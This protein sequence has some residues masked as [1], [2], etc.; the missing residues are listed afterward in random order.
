MPVPPKALPTDG[1][2]VSDLK[3][4]P[5]SEEAVDGKLRRSHRLRIT[6]KH[7]V[8][9]NTANEIFYL[10][11][12][13]RSTEFTGER[14][15]TAIEGE[16]EFEHFH[17]Y[18]L[19]RDLCSALDVL[20][21]ASGE[22]YGSSIL[23]N[24]ARSVIGVDVDPVA[25]AHARTAYGEVNLRFVQGSALD[26]P[27]G[28]ASVDVVVSFDTL[29]YVREHARFMAEVKRVLRPNGKL[30]VSS[31]E[32]AVYS[33][34]GEPANKYHLHELTEAEFESL[35][36][37]NFKHVGILSQQAIFGS[38][39]VKTEGGGPWRSY[40]RR[41]LEYIEA[42][43][44][45]TRAPF[46]IAVASDEE[47]LH[48]PSSVYL[49][50]RRPGDVVGGHLQLPRYRPQ[51][52]EMT[53]EIGCLNEAAA[54]RDA[55]IGR[56]ND[57]AA[58]RQAEIERLNEA[59]SA[60]DRELS[61]VKAECDAQIVWLS[62][63]RMRLNGQLSVDAAKLEVL[64][65]Q[66]DTVTQSFAWRF[67]DEAVHFPRT[68]GRVL[69]G[70]FVRVAYH[71]NGRPRSWLRRLRYMSGAPQAAG[72]SGQM[73]IGQQDGWPN[74]SAET[75]S[76]TPSAGSPRAERPSLAIDV[77]KAT[78]LI[79][80]HEATRSG[81]PILALNLVQQL[82]IRYNVISLTLGGGELTDYFRHVSAALYVADRRTMTDKQLNDIVNG[83]TARHSVK[84]AIINSVASSRV[85]S[86]LRAE[87]VPTISLIHEFSSYMRPRSALHDMIDL[88]TETVFS[89][90]LTL[91]SAVSDFWLYQGNSIHVAP[92]GKCIVPAPGVSNAEVEKTWLAANLRPPGASKFLVLG[93]G[94]IELRK[95]VD[96]FIKCAS[97]L[98][99]K[100]GGERFHFV[101][102]GDGFDPENEM[103]YSV[104]LDDQI[105]RAGLELKLKMLRSTSQIELAY[106]S[107]DLLLITSRLDPLPNVAIDALL[108]GRP[109]L[110][111]EKTTGIADFMIENGLGDQCVAKYL[112]THD[113]AE[114]VKA[115]ADSEELRACV[116]DRSRAAA[117]K[118]FDM[119]VYV[120]R[121]E[122]IAMRAVAHD[123][124]SKDESKA[125]LTSGKFRSDFFKHA[126][127][128]EF[129]EEKIIEDYLH[130]MD[131]GLGVRKPMPGFQPSVYSTL[132]TSSGEVKGDPFAD[133]LRNGLPEGPWLQR[134]IQD[135]GKQN[136]SA[137][138]KA[139]VAMHVHAFYSD[140]LRGIV[141]RLNRNASAPDL[142][143][144]VCTS[145]GAAQ[146][147]EAV[148]TY[149][150]RVVDLQITPN[151]GRDIGPF[152]TQFG[153]ELCADY[154]ITGHLHTKKSLHVTDRPFAEAWNT[155]L[156]ENLVGGERGGA[157]LDAILSAMELD[158]AIGIV[159]PDDPHVISWTK[160]RTCAE[161][162]A[163]R[164]KLGKLPAEFNFPVG[165]MFWIRSSVLTK[166]VELGLA[167]DDYAPEP[168]PIDGTIVHAI[169]R[170]LGVAPAAL[171]M[172]C[173]VTNVRGLTR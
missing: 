90:K 71:K 116:A 15:T 107:A 125:I 146:A 171:G 170:L 160:N 108:A 47:I 11:L 104:Y 22:G 39:I 131:C 102:I 157:A 113:L 166:F 61:S 78:I 164:M 136:A 58:M 144:S 52:V 103:A 151:L 27:L 137:S 112:D 31:H 2:E 121:I 163:A 128:V 67:V 99:D 153:R 17:R 29:E 133:F 89:T 34:R 74:P 93:I 156:M 98:K 86:P 79:V 41:S 8:E 169:E 14:M 72:G 7:M 59:I 42:S 173:A 21:V 111:F 50:R 91:A 123:A 38:L 158:P 88:S 60:R 120:K 130:R 46:L 70:P 44:G 48:V 84:F 18:C 97:I 19:A 35:L 147:R 143:V 6:R 118:E 129:S 9:W 68:V 10:S 80:A 135:G 43:G 13:K 110:C 4:S 64:Q 162:L 69:R 20:D 138:G 83:I 51:T 75:P 106:Q 150:G 96:L 30:I 53:A 101:W 115:L 12:P 92:Q 165:S 154:D 24:I 109:V 33:D 168:L 126:G 122:A 105:K 94:N 114:K 3:S 73:F 172:T 149:R 36:R 139:R 65:G 148:S 119:N 32:R 49:D 57:A 56:L 76:L 140:Q 1:S 40:E 28:D 63:E 26:L 167:W 155:L 134:V 81:A 54:T 37:A 152:L 145:E 117:E 5:K 159:F 66:F 95:G 132:Q 77:R 82:S 142:F 23:A 127:V 62:D 87:G 124:R 45:L 25:I 85:L 16:S 141:E 161:D 55:E 100:S